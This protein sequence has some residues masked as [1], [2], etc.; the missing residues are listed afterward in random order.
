MYMPALLRQA[1]CMP[2][3]SDSAVF[4]KDYLLT[5][6]IKLAASFPFL[7]LV[8]WLVA[9]FCLFLLIFLVWLLYF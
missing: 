5:I 6:K 2:R 7:V 8:G 9:V 1:A 4:Y 3:V